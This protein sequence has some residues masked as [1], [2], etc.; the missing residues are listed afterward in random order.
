MEM[1]PE[2]KRLMAESKALIVQ[3]QTKNDEALKGKIDATSF[4][5]FKANIEPRL[6]AI[7]AALVKLQ[8]PAPGPSEDPTKRELEHKAAYVK[9]LRQGKSALTPAEVKVMTISDLTTGGY[10]AAPNELV[11]EILANVTE[12][13]PIR[14]LARV[15]STSAPGVD[16][17]K[18]TG[19]FSAYRTSE[20]G[21]RTE[22]EGLDY[23]LEKIPA[24]EM[25]ALV[26]VSKQ[27]IE[28]TAFPL[29]S[30]ITAEAAEQ[31][32]VKEGTEGISGTGA[33]GQMR[34]P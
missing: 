26:K 12:Y 29:E 9:F 18:K 4:N 23:G 19:T 8:A 22:T 21:T 10:L 5:E 28:D 20:I 32:G 14:S 33:S 6:E 34:R 3:L 15:I 24:D 17:P 25:Y 13:S 16:W 30:F 1:D 11:K 2:I 27:N 7:S 31:F